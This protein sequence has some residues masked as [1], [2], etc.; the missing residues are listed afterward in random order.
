MKPYNNLTE[1]DKNN[2]IIMFN[3]GFEF[4]D[5]I[6]ALQV[7]KR[8]VAR[9][10]KEAEINTKRRNRYTLNE[11]YFKEIDSQEKSY[12]LGLLYA[13]GFVGNEKFNNIVISLIEQDKCLLERI[14][15][16]IE[17]TGKLRYEKKGGNY[18]NSKPKIVLNFSSKRMALDLRNL[19]IYPGKSA[20]LQKIPCINKKFIRHFIR[21]Y[22]DGD[23][24][25][26]LGLS[27][28]Y[29]KMKDGSIKIYRYSSPRFSIIGTVAFL[30]DMERY[31]PGKFSYT[32][33]RTEYMKYLECSAR[34]DMVNIFE[35]LYNDANI[36]LERKFNKWQE[37]LSAINK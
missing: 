17:F 32:N 26:S 13:D 10:L 22:F 9:V 18:K 3:K 1:V 4:K 14:A 16:E 21:G 6:E 8:S 23:G 34:R 30:K 35:Y 2:I 36:Y 31:I 33:S 11:F 27:T 28:S 19:G 37:V 7:S 20:E 5:I 24:S 15:S 29:H 25:I 12:I